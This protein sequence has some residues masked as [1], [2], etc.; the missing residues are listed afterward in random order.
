MILQLIRKA[1]QHFEDSLRLLALEA[2]FKKMESEEARAI[3]IMISD[4][5]E[6]EK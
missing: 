5:E 6:N 3:R 4:F 2:K 1:F